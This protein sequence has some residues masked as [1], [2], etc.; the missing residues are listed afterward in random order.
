MSLRQ[1]LGSSLG[2]H[3]EAAVQPNPDSGAKNLSHMGDSKTVVK[4]QTDISHG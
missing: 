2:C 4:D 3:C 1:A